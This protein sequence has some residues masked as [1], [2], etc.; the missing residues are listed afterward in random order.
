MEN[1][2]N[3]PIKK[4]NLTSHLAL[5]SAKVA[6]V[7]LLSLG[8]GSIA[9]V[10]TGNLLTHYLARIINKIEGT[11]PQNV[12]SYQLKIRRIGEKYQPVL[13]RNNFGLEIRKRNTKNAMLP[14][15]T[16]LFFNFPNIASYPSSLS[17][18]VNNRISLVFKDN[19]GYKSGGYC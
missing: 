10:L 6:I 8:F 11:S 4:K 15:E 12:E 9:V 13:E 7:L 17:A 1:E 16:R 19:S 2:P 5:F 18:V 3:S 14:P